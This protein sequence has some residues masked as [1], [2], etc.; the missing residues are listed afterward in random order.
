MM[1]SAGVFIKEVR[2]KFLV[3]RFRLYFT[4]A[5]LFVVNAALVIY[6]YRHG[7]RLLRG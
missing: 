5:A 4:A 6:L 1:G 2:R 3:R 7:G